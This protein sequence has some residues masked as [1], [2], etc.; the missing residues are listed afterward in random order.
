VSI[1]TLRFILQVAAIATGGGFVQLLIFVLKRRSELRSLDATAGSTALA[2]ANSYITT[3]QGGEK[4][5]RDELDRTHGRLESLQEQWDVERDTLTNALDNQR[6]EV[7]RLAADL[8]RCR[9]DLAVADARIAELTNSPARHGR[10]STN[11]DPRQ[12]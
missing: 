12:A 3:L 6:H 5:V 4:A 1:D 11:Y 10:W 7:A 2:S 8:A 9:A